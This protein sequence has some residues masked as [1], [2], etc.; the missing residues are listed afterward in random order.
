[1]FFEFSLQVSSNF[2]FKVIMGVKEERL[3]DELRK[4]TIVF[5]RPDVSKHV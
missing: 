3:N 4:N 2:L 1:M 5:T